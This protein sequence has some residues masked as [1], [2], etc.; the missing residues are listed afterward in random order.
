M[1]FR[2]FRDWTYFVSLH[3]TVL[4][5]ETKIY[6]LFNLKKS[7]SIEISVVTIPIVRLGVRNRKLTIERLSMSVLR[8]R[9]GFPSLPCHDKDAQLAIFPW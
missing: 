5:H 6:H 9:V 2:I 7:A 8:S 3:I 1:I 4:G